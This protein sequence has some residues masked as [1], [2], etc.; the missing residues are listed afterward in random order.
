MLHAQWTD[1][2]LPELAQLLL[3]AL[4]TWEPNKAPKWAYELDAAVQKR[5]EV[6]K[7]G[8]NGAADGRS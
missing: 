6:L 7:E 3:R 4:N 8:S 2:E 5:L 1:E